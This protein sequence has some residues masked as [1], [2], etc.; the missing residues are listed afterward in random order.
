[1]YPHDRAW[2]RVGFLGGI[3][4]IVRRVVAAAVVAAAAAVAGGHGAGCVEVSV[5]PTRG[6][7]RSCRH[8]LHPLLWRG[9]DTLTHITGIGVGS[10]DRIGAFILNNRRNNC[11]PLSILDSKLQQLSRNPY[12]QS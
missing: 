12:L 4:V 2:V 6:H 10:F 3:L 11:D 7:L 1:M 8:L 5:A 9:S